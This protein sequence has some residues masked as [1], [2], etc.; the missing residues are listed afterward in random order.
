MTVPIFHV[1]AMLHSVRR[2]FKYLPISVAKSRDD[3]GYASLKQA[4][5]KMPES[6][7]SKNKRSYHHEDLSGGTT[8]SYHLYLSLN[9]PRK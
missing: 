8:E 5:D 3:A 4:T 2:T 1:Q 7:P 9:L 6:L